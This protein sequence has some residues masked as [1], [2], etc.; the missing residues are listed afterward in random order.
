MK[1]KFTL[2]AAFFNLRIFIGLALC[3]IGLVM[4]LAGSSKSL[5]GTIAATQDSNAHHQHHHYKFIDLGT[6][7]GPTSL[8]DLGTYPALNNQ[9]TVIGMA[10]TTTLDPF[11]PN[12]PL[13]Y[14]SDPYIF[15]AFQWQNG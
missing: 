5:T 7:G 6:F 8:N 15:K 9:G 13:L 3:S 10:D 12:D 14:G 1:T 2:S 11:Y 4:A